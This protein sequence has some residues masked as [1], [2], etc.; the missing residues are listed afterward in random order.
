MSTFFKR[1]SPLLLIFLGLILLFWI[2]QAIPAGA[3]LLVG[4][5]IIVES[6]WPEKWDAD[7]KK[8]C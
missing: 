2:G 1:L 8:N 7:N 5:V 6:I 3:C 4:I